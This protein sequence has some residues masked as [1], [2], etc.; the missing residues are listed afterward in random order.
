[1]QLPRPV[2]GLLVAFSFLA[3]SAAVASDVV[4]PPTSRVGL[5][6][7]KGMVA[8]RSFQGFEDT[9][10]KAA[11][12]FTELPP[13]AYE[14]LEKAATADALKQP[15]LTLTGREPLAVD[16]GKAIL[17]TAKQEN[18]GTAVHKWLL[19]ATISDLT[20][21]ASAEVPQ[22]AGATY[23]DAAIRTA[24]Q[25]MKVRPDPIA[26]K[27]DLLP[28]KVAD[29]SGFRFVRAQPTSALLTDGPQDDIDVAQPFMFISIGGITAA[30]LAE[31]D[32][33]AR[34]SLRSIPGF[35]DVRVTSAEAQRIRGQAGY[36]V[37]ADAKNAKTG[38]DVMLVQWLRFGSSSFL[39]MIGIVPKERWSDAF[40]RLRAI[41]DGVEPR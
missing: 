11:I 18:G 20:V 14:Q 39:R 7:P 4:F 3:A 33:F 8:S 35:T 29:L 41:R 26:E 37:R 22:T 30:Q 28:F 23:P 9:D 21:L 38:A 24:L 15:G 25:S 13:Q 36:E 12:V 17:W 2:T 19:L 1:M 34:E 27:I 16:G 6:P 32:A 5:V 40:P 10:K 31:R